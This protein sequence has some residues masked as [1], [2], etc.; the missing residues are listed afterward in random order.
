MPAVTVSSRSWSKLDKACKLT[1][2]L[3]AKNPLTS[4]YSPDYMVVQ[5]WPF[6]VALYSGVEQALK[7]LL[8]AQPNP[9]FTLDDLKKPRL[10]HNLRGL[11]AALPPDDREHIELHFRGH[12][13]LYEYDTHGQVICTAEDF[14]AHING[15]GKPGGAVS[16]R[17]VLVEEAMEIPA[18]SLWTM[19]E[20]WS[21]VNC[22]VRT[23]ALDTQGHCFRLSRMLSHKFKWLVLRT[24]PM[25]YDEFIDEVN[26][27]IL[28]KDRDHLAAWIDLFVKASHNALDEVQATE[29]LRSELARMAHKALHQMANE[30]E[31]PDETQ[32]LQRIQ[33][34]PN[35]SWDRTTATFLSAP[36]P[37]TPARAPGAS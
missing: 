32:L 19:C 20:I 27:W 33:D 34:D 7:M 9:R 21:A 26:E 16:W 24:I 37:K 22:R 10:R 31:N 18:T 17:Y 3:V 6:V 8:L 30:P 25:P 2:G 11:Y 1:S 36:K 15:E 35:L 4:D 5:A 12:W 13:S 29:R 23:K 28:H 14:I